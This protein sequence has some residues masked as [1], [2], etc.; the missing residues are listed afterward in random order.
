MKVISYPA[1]LAFILDHVRSAAFTAPVIL[2]IDGADCSG[3]TT[4]ARD[5]LMKAKDEFRVQLFHCDDYI[6]ILAQT[7]DVE[8]CTPM[9][10]YESFFDRKSII[11]SVLSPLSAIKE[12]SEHPY[13]DLVIVEGLFLA[14][15]DLF[16]YFD[17]VVRLEIGSD[18]VLK[19]ALKR[20][21]GVIGD[22]QFVEKHYLKQCIPAQEHYRSTCD[23]KGRSTFIFRINS[24]ISYVIDKQPV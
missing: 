16:H 2:G 22:A 5:L 1:V 4:L 24:Q 14:K 10:F 18:E 6:N 19:R 7:F 9:Q 8:T 3:K 15:D 21:V 23:I 20:D 17:M 11:A 12:R 13:P